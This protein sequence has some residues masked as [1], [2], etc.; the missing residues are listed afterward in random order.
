MLMDRFVLL[1]RLVFA[2]DALQLVSVPNAHADRAQQD[3]DQKRA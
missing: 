3:Y 2:V 1:Q